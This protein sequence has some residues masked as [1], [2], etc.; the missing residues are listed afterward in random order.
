MRRT[1]SHVLIYR[2]RRAA[3]DARF[4]RWGGEGKL[5]HSDTDAPEYHRYF[6][7]GEYA[8]SGVEQ[9]VTLKS[10][11]ID[12]ARER[13][14]ERLAGHTESLPSKG[15]TTTMPND[16]ITPAEMFRLSRST[17]RKLVLAGQDTAAVELMRREVNRANRRVERGEVAA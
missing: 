2:E 1:A 5:D 8:G 11:M 16:T 3:Q 13:L 9:R 6:G 12:L 17:L 10:T 4:T 7:L 14:A 15:A